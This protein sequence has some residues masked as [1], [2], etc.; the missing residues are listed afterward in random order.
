MEI[1]TENLLGNG[2]YR[3]KRKEQVTGFMKADYIC[4][5]VEKL[6]DLPYECILFGGEWGIGKTYAVDVALEKQENVCR[7]SMFGLQSSQ[8]IYH[9]VLF[10]S[11]LKN[12]KAG[13]LG[14]YAADALTGLASIW[15]GLEKAK[16]VMQ[17]VAKEKELFLMLSKTF[18]SLH[19]IVVDDLERISDKVNMEEVLGIIE[20]LKKCSYV[21]V[22]MVANIKELQGNNA[23]I[24]KKYNEKVIDRIY[25]ITER[26]ANI[27]WGALGIHAGFM[28][29]FLK[30]HEVKNL[31]TLQKAQKF[32]DDVKWYCNEISNEQFLDEIKLMCFAIVIESTDKLYYRELKEGEETKEDALFQRLR[33]ELDH[34]LLNYLR[35]IRSRNN[36]WK[37]LLMYYKNEC[38]IT[39]EDMNIEYDMFIEAGEKPIFYQTDAEVEQIIPVLAEKMRN[40]QSINALNKFADEC[41]YWSEVIGK[42]NAEILREYREKLQDILRSVILAG[43]EEVLS[44]NVDSWRLSSEEVKRVYAEEREELRRW[45]MRNYIEYLTETTKGQKAYE[46]SYKLKQYWNHPFYRDMIKEMSEVLYNEKSFPVGDISIEQYDTCYNIMYVLFH[47]DK[48]RFLKYC[49]KISK[50]YDRMSAYRMKKQ[51]EEIAKG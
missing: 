38:A 45:M 10:Q 19:I 27:N 31:R 4:E 35:G 21:K 47:I 50:G 34:R 5:I 49:E 33:N 13:K 2:G 20:E 29:A 9:E 43:E 16:D 23:Q 25:H 17:N 6:N 12:N 7:I 44:Y 32:F 22:I 37:L 28:K 14:E 30:E 8:Q 40:A 46:Y 36:L 42:D 1:I 11:T 41:V 15:S 24:F 26:P 18:N 39:H 3:Q 51:I 48:D